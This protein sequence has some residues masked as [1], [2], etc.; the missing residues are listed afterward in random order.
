MEI[1]DASK[2][3][4]FQTSCLFDQMI[5]RHCCKKLVYHWHSGLDFLIIVHGVKLQHLPWWMCWAQRVVASESFPKT[6]GFWESWGQ[7]PVVQDGCGRRQLGRNR[8][9]SDSEKS[10]NPFHICGQPFNIGVWSFK[11]PSFAMMRRW[12]LDKNELLAW[13][14]Q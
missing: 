12:F 2:S 1:E 6:Q 10:C 3:V 5:S 7:P 11:R 4:R 13:S 9:A 8:G 14:D